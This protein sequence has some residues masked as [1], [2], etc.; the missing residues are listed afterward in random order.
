MSYFRYT[1]HHT[2]LHT[3]LTRLYVPSEIKEQTTAAIGELSLLEFRDLNHHSNAFQ[4]TFVSEIRRLDECE[5]SLSN[6]FVICQLT[7][8]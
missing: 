2:L 6:L 3:A 8:F 7:A 5:R 4:R 1:D